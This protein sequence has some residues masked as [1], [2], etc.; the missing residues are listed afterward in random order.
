MKRTVYKQQFINAFE[1]YGRSENFT[2]AGQLAL[3]EYFTE[4]EEETEI[5]FELDIIGICCA[6]TEYD[7]LQELCKAYGKEYNE[8]EEESIIEY[9]SGKTIILKTA[10]DSFVIENF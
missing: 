9:F 6:Y 10:I 8:E 7:D 3:F 4:L 1:E 5:E 2:T